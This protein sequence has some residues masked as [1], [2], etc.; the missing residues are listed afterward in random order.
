MDSRFRENGMAL[1]SMAEMGATPDLALP[2]KVMI[3]VGV[4]VRRIVG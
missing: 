3:D 2:A 1:L 4:R